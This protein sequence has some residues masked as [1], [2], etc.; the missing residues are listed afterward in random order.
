MRPNHEISFYPIK[1]PMPTSRSMQFKT[2]RANEGTNKEMQKQCSWSSEQNFESCCF[3]FLSV[4]PGTDQWRRSNL[5]WC[6]RTQTVRRHNNQMKGRCNLKKKNGPGQILSV[7]KKDFAPWSV[8]AQLGI[9]PAYE[10]LALLVNPILT[11]CNQSTAKTMNIHLL[12]RFWMVDTKKD[13]FA[14]HQLVSNLSSMKSYLNE[15]LYRSEHTWY[16]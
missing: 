3:V 14:N 12:W 15:I 5:V 8:W 11:F 10:F 2:T 9:G 13:D 4:S 6:H 1:G 7:K 16:L